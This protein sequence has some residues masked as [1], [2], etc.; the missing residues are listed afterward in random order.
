MSSSQSTA[1]AAVLAR[2]ARGQV[3]M[4]AISFL[5]GMG[6]NL[7]GL[8]EEASGAAKVTTAILLALHILIALGLLA[9]AALC[10]WRSGPLTDRDRTW[11]LAGGILVVLTIVAGIL[12][13]ST[14]NN[15]WS[16]VMAVGF[17]LSVVV[18]VN[19][20]VSASRS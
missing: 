1:D 14:D 17:I 18:Y 4:L 20:L 11:A 12:T 3:M 7:I 5:L 2:R 16:F 6:V 13:T 8:P 9:G 19:L 10:L 15:W